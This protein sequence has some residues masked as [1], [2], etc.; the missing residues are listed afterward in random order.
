MNSPINATGK[1]DGGSCIGDEER[2]GQDSV[3][4]AA[5]R[6]C[7]SK[8]CSYLK[9]NYDEIRADKVHVTPLKC[10]LCLGLWQ[11]EEPEEENSTDEEKKCLEEFL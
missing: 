2:Q 11:K 3:Y 8:C 1:Q 9:P 6:L 5:I 4:A 7:C 10:W